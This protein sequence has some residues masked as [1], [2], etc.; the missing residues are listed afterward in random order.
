MQGGDSTVPQD[1]HGWTADTHPLELFNHF[2]PP[3]FRDKQVQW[4]RTHCDNVGAGG[5]GSKDWGGHL[6]R[7]ELDN[8]IAT[9]LLNGLHPYPSLRQYFDL[10]GVAFKDDTVK[11]LWGNIVTGYHRVEHLRKFLRF[12]DPEVCVR[13]K[14]EDI[15]ADVRAMTDDLNGQCESAFEVGKNCSLDEVDIGTQ[16]SFAGAETIKFKV[17][18]DGILTDAICDAL[19][20]A[21]ITF[22]FRKTS[23]AR[24]RRDDPE[25]FDLTPELSPLHFRCLMLF[26]RPCMRDKWRNVWMDNLFPSLR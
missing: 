1:C 3:S 22:R 14:R 18:G 7:Q 15:F 20:G 17:E 6:S 2:H 11:K 9:E 5:I 26:R 8:N 21:L 10:D 19:T 13:N 4:T 25:L 23:M 12:E 16:T 24:M